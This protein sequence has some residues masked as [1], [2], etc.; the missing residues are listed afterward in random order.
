MPDRAASALAQRL[1]RVL[2]TLALPA[3]VAA[4]GGNVVVDGMQAGAG[5]AAGTGGGSSTSAST[6]GAGGSAACIVGPHCTPNGPSPGPQQTLCFA[7]PPGQPC[8]DA[9]QA[10][11]FFTPGCAAVSSVQAACAGGTPGECCY[12]VTAMCTC[13]GRPFLVDGAPRTASSLPGD[14]RGWRSDEAPDVSDLPRATRD[15]LAT[16]FTEDALGE[17]ASV[18]S[19][20][21][22]A[23]ELMAV[24]APAALVADAHRAAL[25]EVRHAQIAFGLASAFG[26]AAVSPGAFP[27]PPFAIRTDL[28]SF[29]RAV[30]VEG[31]IGET[32]AALVAAE[33][34]AEA[35][36]PRVSAALASIAEDEARHAELAWR[37][38]AWALSVGGADV[39]EVVFTAL[40]EAT[41]LVSAV[42]RTL[43]APSELRS[44]GVIGARATNA[45]LAAGIADVVE[46]CARSLRQRVEVDGR[47]TRVSAASM[48]D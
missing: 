13:K 24:G 45:L 19:F 8:P 38:I 47:S 25:D 11:P 15:A 29:A 4:C 22:F 5:G 14:G 17:H 21:R 30:A 35:T 36:E 37:T 39:A 34:A 32:L 33:R 9:T 31:C 18:A 43:S 42:P 16:A 27:F 3:G 28:V 44:F 23:L 12:N 20:G 7:P 1:A 2:S 40:A 6:T 41:R 10:L 26:G 46:P 48:N